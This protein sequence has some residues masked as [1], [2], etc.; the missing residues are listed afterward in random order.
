[1]KNVSNRSVWCNLEQLYGIGDKQGVQ[2]W[3]MSSLWWKV[4]ASM[5]CCWYHYNWKVKLC[6]LS[7]YIHVVHGLKECKQALIAHATF[8]LCMLRSTFYVILYF[9]MPM[10]IFKTG[11]ENP[12]WTEF[13]DLVLKTDH[14]WFAQDVS[15]NQ[16]ISTSGIHPVAWMKLI[17]YIPF[18]LG[19]EQASGQKHP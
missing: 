6:T 4:V 2:Y 8:S 17:I 13:S 18:N 7:R 11:T 15:V 1:M 3:E 12:V 5:Y 14:A 19:L 9:S 10:F 16:C